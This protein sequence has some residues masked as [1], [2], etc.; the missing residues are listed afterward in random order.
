MFDVSGG[1]AGYRPGF[2]GQLTGRCSAADCGSI[3]FLLF[4]LERF[5]V[6]RMKRR[7]LARLV[8]YRT[9]I[10]FRLNWILV[11]IGATLV[12]CTP[13]FIHWWLAVLWGFAI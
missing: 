9:S 12:V 5:K 2:N 13:I 4:L 11:H 3:F 7:H 8:L 1:L 10:V 6:A